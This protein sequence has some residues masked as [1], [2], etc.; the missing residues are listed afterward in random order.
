MTDY[1]Y[2]EIP[3]SFAHIQREYQLLWSVYKSTLTGLVTSAQNRCSILQTLSSPMT[4]DV[5]KCNRRRWSPCPSRSTAG[6]SNSNICSVLRCSW[7]GAI[8][9]AHEVALQKVDCRGSGQYNIL[10]KAHILE[11][12]KCTL[13]EITLIVSKLHRFPSSLKLTTGGSLYSTT[14]DT[15]TFMA[16]AYV[17]PKRDSLKLRN[18]GWFF[19]AITC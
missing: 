18:S 10:L 9:T 4:Q 3:R 7:N 5:R 8:A 6:T 14:L 12:C 2:H 15:E 16:N 1:H 13:S 11:W 19:V 17:E